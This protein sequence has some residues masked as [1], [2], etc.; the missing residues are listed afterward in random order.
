MADEETIEELRVMFGINDALTNLYD[1]EFVGFPKPDVS[2]DDQAIEKYL[3]YRVMGAQVYGGEKGADLFLTYR[4]D[5]NWKLYQYFLKMH[6]EKLNL[7]ECKVNVYAS[8]IEAAKQQPVLTFAYSNLVID[9]V[10]PLKFDT[11]GKGMMSV[12]VCFRY[13]KMEPKF[14]YEFDFQKKEE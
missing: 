11:L 3:S 12:E 1:V 14:N 5:R 4:V 9:T 13:E 7:E 6:K 8:S 10:G 2:E